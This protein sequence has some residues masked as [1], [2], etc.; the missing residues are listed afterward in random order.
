MADLTNVVE[1][2]L[3]LN[4][5]SLK[6]RD[7]ADQFEY[8]V[9]N[10]F[11]YPKIVA[12]TE[13]WLNDEI[14][15]SHFQCS[16]KY[17]IYRKDRTGRDG[18]GVALFVHKDVRSYLIDS[19]AFGEVDVVWVMTI[20]RGGKYLVGTFY[21]PPHCGVEH[22]RQ[23]VENIHGM[24]D[25]YPSATPL[26][27]G[28]FNFS[29]IDWVEENAPNVD[30]QAD[31][32]LD[33]LSLGMSQFVTEPTNGINT[34]DLVFSNEPFLVTDIIHHPPLGQ[35]D[36]DI[37][38]VTTP[39]NSRKN[40]PKKTRIDWES[41]NYPAIISALESTDWP[42]VFSTCTDVEHFWSSL[43]SILDDLIAKYIPHKIINGRSHKRKSRIIQKLNSKKCAAHKAKKR[44]PQNLHKA[45]I[46]KEASMSLKKAIEEHALKVEQKILKCSSTKRFYQ[47]ATSKFKAK[48][49]IPPLKLQNVVI[50]EDVDKATHLNDYFTSVF[51]ADNGI[52]PD[53]PPRDLQSCINNVTFEPEVIAKTTKT[54]K[55]SLSTGPDGYPSF[56]LKKI[57]WPLAIPLSSIFEVSLRTKKVP[58][59]WRLA[60]VTPI[61]KGK[62]SR[63]DRA[64]YRPIS[65]TS[66]VC[67]IMEKIIRSAVFDHLVDN[68]I[69]SKDQH[70]F[71][72]QYSTQTQLLEFLDWVTKEVDLGHAV[73]VAY[74]DI[75]KAFDTVSHPKLLAR[76]EQYGVWGDLLEWFAAFLSERQQ[77]VCIDGNFSD[78]APVISGV[79]QGTVL[80]P[81]LFLIFI[82]E[83]AEIVAPSNI[84]LYADD[85]KVYGPASTPDQA[86]IIQN[87]LEVLN[88][89]VSK[90]QLKL[91]VQ[92]CGVMHL[93][94]R[95]PK[96]DYV[97]AGTN[98]EKLSSIS[99]LG[100]IISDNLKPSDH[101][102]KIAGKAA[103]RVGLLF[104]GF[105]NRDPKFQTDMFKTYVRPGPDYCASAWSPWLV[106]DRQAVEKIQRRF[107][108]RVE[109][110]RDLSYQERL[111]R[112]NLEPLSARR[113]QAD[114]T[115]TFKILSGTHPIQADTLFLE[116]P[117][118]VTRENGRKLYAPRTHHDFRKHFFSSR[119]VSVWNSL[120]ADVV[121][122]QSVACFKDRISRVIF[123]PDESAIYPLVIPQS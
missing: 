72:S 9:M 106:R 121:N 18:G 5:R 27:F 64:N 42:T 119:V 62:G 38:E 81:V 7:K 108:K 52:T 117:S 30:G 57:A 69:I 54:F 46:F 32:L 13:T 71:R 26:I 39:L 112:L 95:N 1:S 100:V 82:N 107:S 37:L 99:D 90:W 113:L 19:F 122:S 56:F 14:I 75:A 28:D 61:Y 11:N 60:N 104:R 40:L 20:F 110:L 48:P 120:P 89:W 16:T 8:E 21:R 50:E 29:G 47:Y 12:V 98:L 123:S 91:A 35:S 36:H 55:N 15:N 6:S 10:H 59:D 44:D 68:D 53:V 86:Q 77:R 66:V 102:A 101:I 83:M 87:S 96:H 67:K 70:G 58:R 73:D 63:H 78:W 93:G 105:R 76:L 115:E 49:C 51:V 79:P 3:Y 116:A 23:M 24:V 103:S 2:F 85:A 80:G 114:M 33:M 17:E 4:A 118:R 41:G 65:L 84:K 88:S 25:R 94:H 31:F 111:S 45:H 109:G 97:L 74:L 22:T 43:K 92:K 34:L